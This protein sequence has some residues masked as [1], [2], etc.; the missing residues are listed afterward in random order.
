MKNSG[1]IDQ[2]RGA[3]STSLQRGDR[4][5][6]SLA[7]G[8]SQVDTEPPK[9]QNRFNGFSRRALEVMKPLKRFSVLILPVITWLKPGANEI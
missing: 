4:R 1:K 5:H 2:F 6:L 3:L 7:P 8:F 9:T